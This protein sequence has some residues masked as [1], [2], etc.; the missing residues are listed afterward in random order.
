LQ[1]QA[2]GVL[3]LSLWGF[4]MGMALCIPL[5]LL[6]H[7]LEGGDRAVSESPALA[8]AQLEP[9]F[10]EQ[11]FDVEYFTDEWNKAEAAKRAQRR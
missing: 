3:A 2:I 6:F 4:V 9:V 8:P 5:G 10:Q 11:G 7:A 1:A